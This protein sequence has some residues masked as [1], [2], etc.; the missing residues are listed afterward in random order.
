[1]TIHP[2]ETSSIPGQR[3]ATTIDVRQADSR[4]GAN[5]TIPS[6]RQHV[7]SAIRV[8]RQIVASVGTDHHAFDRLVDWMDLWLANHVGDPQSGVRCSVTMQYGTSR[9]PRLADGAALLAHQELK[10][11][12]ASASAVVTHGGPATIRDAFSAGLRPFVVPRDPRFG[13]HVDDHQIRFTRM[14]AEQGEIILCRERDQL[15][16]AL[17][18]SVS[19]GAWSRVDRASQQA[20]T[21][22]AIARVA[23]ILDEVLAAS[24][25][26]RHR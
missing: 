26:R 16:E 1:M 23:I 10:L 20:E 22:V 8:E 4:D 24:R 19:E 3:T 14:L 5:L 25:R 21:Q 15:F 13:E 9:P 6:A 18:R 7:D 2:A 12:M 11:A 17:D